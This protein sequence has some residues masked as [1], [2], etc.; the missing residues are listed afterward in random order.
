MLT[1]TLQTLAAGLALL[2]NTVTLARRL[3][4]PPRSGE[5]NV[6]AS[7]VVQRLPGEAFANT[8]LL[9]ADLRQ[10]RAELEAVGV[11]LSKSAIEL[12][13]EANWWRLRRN[14]V[15][16]SIRPRLQGI[17]DT[18]AVLFSDL[19][20]VAQCYNVEELVSD[21]FKDG[22]EQQENIRALT[23][24]GRPLKDII[25]VTENLVIQIADQLRAVR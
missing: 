21:V 10:L 14:R 15:V 23:E 25:T 16:H 1:A 8:Q 5:V 12:E 4:E 11:D 20:A 22:G 18:F 9:L 7:V 19:V 3:G 6:S 2:E 24:P 17:S 13:A